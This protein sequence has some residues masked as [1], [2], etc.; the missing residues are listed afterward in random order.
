MHKIIARCFSTGTILCRKLP[1]TYQ[2]PKY[3]SAPVNNKQSK[4]SEKKAKELRN[5]TMVV[6][7]S[8][9]LGWCLKKR[10]DESHN[11]SNVFRSGFGERF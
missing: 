7:L 11:D 9:F 1:K 6:G 5:A 10:Y 8:I 2:K 4:T 3:E